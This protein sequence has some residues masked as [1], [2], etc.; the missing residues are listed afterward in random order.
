VE[1]RNAVHTVAAG[2]AIVVS[3]GEWVRYSPAQTASSTLPCAYR[4]F[5][6]ELFIG[7][8][9]ELASLRS[10]FDDAIAVAVQGVIDLDDFSCRSVAGAAQSGTHKG[11]FP[12]RMP[13]RVQRFLIG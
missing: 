2:Q 3:A 10:F 13:G 12:L 7:T 4:R 6:L 1:T 5:R 11:V 9:D 8:S